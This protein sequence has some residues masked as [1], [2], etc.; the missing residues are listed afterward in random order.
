MRHKVNKHRELRIGEYQTMS[1]V[2]KT[3][4][5]NFVREGH[6]T[7]TSKRAK[8]IKSEADA[9]FG[10]L[11]RMFDTYKDEKDVRREAIRY[12]KLHLSGETEG[13]RVINELMPKYRQEGKKSGFVSAY[14]LG[15]RA[16]DGAEK[17]LL[18]L[19]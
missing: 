17:V 3:M 4:L 9:F 1:N 18:R 8:I 13:K 12:V 14:K 5:T 11:I 7:T 16:G 2:I 19:V 10:A 6:M 15:T